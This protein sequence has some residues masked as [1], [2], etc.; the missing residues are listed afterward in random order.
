MK[1]QQFINFS[2]FGAM[3]G[4]VKSVVPSA[5]AQTATQPPSGSE[6]AKSVATGATPYSPDYDRIKAAQ[7]G[8]SAKQT[9][10]SKLDPR[11]YSGGRK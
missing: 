3:L 1:R 4:L 8:I 9:K 5:V 7:T 2:I 6:T 10:I 11:R